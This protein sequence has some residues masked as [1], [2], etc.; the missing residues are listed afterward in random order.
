LTQ[1]AVVAFPE[2][3]QPAQ[4]EAIRKRFDPMAGVLGFHVTIVFPFSGPPAVAE[5][6][7]RRLENVAPFDF[8][9]GGPVRG[10]EVYVFLQVMRGVGAFL[11]LHGSLYSAP[12]APHLSSEHRYVPHMTIGRLPTAEAANVAIETAAAHIPSAMRGTVRSLALYRTR[13]SATGRSRNHFS[14]LKRRADNAFM[15]LLLFFAPV[16]S[17]ATASI[18]AFGMAAC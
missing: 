4:I 12:L 1:Y 13:R 2:L 6:V 15:F 5:H 17:G 3:E 14:A 11:E 9:L 7:Q 8:E 10:D 18:S 16:L